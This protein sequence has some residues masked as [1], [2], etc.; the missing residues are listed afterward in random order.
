MVVIVALMLS[1]PLFAD[2]VGARSWGYDIRDGKVKII[3]LYDGH[4]DGIGA[5]DTNP[6]IGDVQ[7]VDW[8]VTKPTENSQVMAGT[9]LTYPFRLDRRLTVA[10]IVGFG[11]DLTNDD[12]GNKEGHFVIGGTVEFAW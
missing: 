2:G 7:R 10:P 9:G 6:F 11:H 12:G 8:V 5:F 4:D 3:Y 1:A